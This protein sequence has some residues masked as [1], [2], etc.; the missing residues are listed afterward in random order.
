MLCGLRQE[1]FYGECPACGSLGI[2]TIPTNLADYYP[3]DYYSFHAP[4]R[5][6]KR[7]K[8][9][10]T[11]LSQWL[12]QSNSFAG[13]Q[14]IG[15]LKR[16]YPF[17]QWCRLAQCGLNSR[18]LDVGCGSGGLLRRMQRHGFS[19][20][21]GVDPYAPTEIEEPGFLLKRA[22]LE[23]APGSYDLIMM[24]HVLEHVADPDAL[25]R[26]ARAKLNPGGKVLVRIPLAA[27]LS[28]RTYRENWFNLDPPRHLLVPSQAGFVSLAGRVGFRVG[29]I[30]WD[31]SEIAYLMSE[32]Y[33]K[34]ISYQE[35]KH[36]SYWRRVRFRRLANA[37]NRRGQGD[38]GIFLL[39]TD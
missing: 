10:S 20:L 17:F 1:F 9:G 36:E 30:G 29:Y 34:G 32:N 33:R 12:L 22:E 26:A 6:P 14:L 25:L 28:W 35:R 24:H 8:P 31:G 2:Q 21:T 16:K 3:S 37:A 7:P 5:R 18:I 39:E 13:R 11:V 38:Q 15:A 19:N 27:S 4:P 23:A